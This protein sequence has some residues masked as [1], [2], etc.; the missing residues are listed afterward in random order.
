[1]RMMSRGRIIL[2]LFGSRRSSP[3]ALTSRICR[4]KATICFWNFTRF[5]SVAMSGSLLFRPG[6]S[7]GRFAGV[8]SALRA[9]GHAEGLQEPP[10]LVVAVGAGHEAHVHALREV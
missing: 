6:S 4:S 10:R 7:R 9:E 5:G 1:M 2:A 8:R 3:A